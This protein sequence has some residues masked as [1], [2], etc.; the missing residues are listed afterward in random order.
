V[1]ENTPVPVQM[2]DTF[3]PSYGM[4]HYARTPTRTY[5]WNI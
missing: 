1:G 5:S 4:K 2:V 3:M